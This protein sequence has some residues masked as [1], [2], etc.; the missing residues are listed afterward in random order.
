VE[1]LTW[2]ATGL[3]TYLSCPEKFRRRYI[4][5]EQAEYLSA[6]TMIGRSVHHALRLAC[7]ARR[8]GQTAV[9]EFL[10]EN[11]L[12]HFDGLVAQDAESPDPISW[13]DDTLDQRREDIKR[14][15]VLWQQKS[16]NFWRDYGEPVVVEEHFTVELWGHRVTGVFDMVSDRGVV[17]DWKTGKRAMSEKKAERELQVLVY[18]AAHEA[19]FGVYPE[20]LAFVQVVRNRPTQSRPRWTYTLNIQER[21]T[22]PEQKELLHQMLDRTAAAVEAG[23]YPLNISSP[24]CQPEW[25]G[26]WTTCPAR[27]IKA[28][29][30]RVDIDISQD[31]GEEEA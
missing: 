6:G 18:P 17:V 25:C 23:H 26:F 8:E 24:F 9:L 1:P 21:P 29:S 31:Q 2:H 3:S 22:D 19:L 14:L 15:V 12:A 20:R 16:P 27:F 5:R 11:A 30:E 13:V 7:E 4:E 28:K 10:I